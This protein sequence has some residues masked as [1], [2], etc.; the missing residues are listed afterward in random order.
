M[1]NGETERP[2]FSKRGAVD[3]HG[4]MNK[5]LTIPNLESAIIDEAEG[6][7]SEKELLQ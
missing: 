4:M 1:E 2:I 7:E 6:D 3:L 5:L